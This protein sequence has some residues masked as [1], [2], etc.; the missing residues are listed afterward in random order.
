M[1]SPRVM[2]VITGLF[3]GGG[4]ETLLLRLLEALGDERAG[5]SVVS[6][7]P[8]WALAHDIERL[9]VP[10]HAVGMS[11][12]PTP[13]D[14]ARLGRFLRRSD[15]EVIQTWMLHAN[16]LGLIARMVSRSPVVWGVH[17]SEVSRSTLG[18][19]AVVV[20]RCEAICSWFVPSLIVA[21]S[22]S[23]QEVMQRLR[24]RSQRIVT[25]PNGFDVVR[26]KPDVAAGKEVR[27]EL[28]LPATTTVIGHLARFHPIKDHGTLLAAA[29]EVLGQAPDVRFV[30]CGDGVTSENPQLS[31]LTAPLG[32][33][34]LMLGQRDD[35]PRL[36][37]AF[38]LA[39]SSS[40][41]EALPLAIG[42]AMATGVPVV[43]TRCGDSE[44]LIADTGALAPVGDPRALA[45][46]MV[47]LIKLDPEMR[48]ELGRRARARISNRYSLEGMVE[49]YQQVWADVGPVEDRAATPL[50]GT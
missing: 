3:P 22:A 23:S 34:V 9:G 10:V 35:I 13:A 14:L 33:G 44:K 5:H 7:R 27:R 12:R 24:Y 30:L 6:L 25:I 15:A 45:E 31:E 40:S 37:N 49:R 43:A 48:M 8:R 47:E 4:A 42:E 18:T 46:A 2:H 19:K 21:C 11:G 41:G 29:A 38:D 1:N 32:D 50:P 36:L 17:L 20:Q 26:F 16:V 39:V 28:G